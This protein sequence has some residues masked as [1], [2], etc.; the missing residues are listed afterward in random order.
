MNSRVADMEDWGER[1]NCRQ[2]LNLG[3]VYYYNDCVINSEFLLS[4]YPVPS[5]VYKCRLNEEYTHPVRKMPFY[6]ILQIK[7]KSLKEMGFR[8][9]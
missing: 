3:R 9:E 8:V 2:T 4:A 7:T 6:L 1:Q 5:K